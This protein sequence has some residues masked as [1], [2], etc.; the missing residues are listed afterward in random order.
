VDP[1]LSKLISKAKSGEKKMLRFS[2]VPIQI[3]QRLLVVAM[4]I[5][6]LLLLS[7]CAASGS[8][9][10]QDEFR[11]GSPAG[12]LTYRSREYGF[13]FSYPAAWQLEEGDQ[14]LKL[15]KGG[16]Q[17]RV[18]FNWADEVESGTVFGRTG[19]AAGDLL[20]RGKTNFMGKAMP[21]Q[22]LVYEL[23]D[24]AVLYNGTNLIEVGDLVFMIA[25]EEMSF[26][27]E[28]VQISEADQR[29]SL[30]IIE[31]FER[32][33]AKGTAGKLGTSPTVR[34]GRSSHGRNFPPPMFP[35]TGT[36]L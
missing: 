11:A 33:Q 9:P 24:K 23:K 15:K 28:D 34:A 25:L 2:K 3:R 31:S 12:Q 8:D 27:Y 32:I 17:L 19:I 13:E 36:H 4:L 18:D 1:I 20:Y 29:E 35:A 21:V 10:A 30:S 26:P 6:P 16:L 7:A 5:P 14:Y 22:V